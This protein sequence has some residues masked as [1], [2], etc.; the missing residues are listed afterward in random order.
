MKR[1]TISI[2]DDLEAG[3]DAYM[4]EQEAPP[5]LTSVVQAALRS[6]LDE[7][8]WKDRAYRSPRRRLR[9]PV[10]KKGS[11]KKDVSVEHDKYLAK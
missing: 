8:K 1:A 6:Y 11:G 5:S 3:L 4:K 10:A 2:P 7:H 9:I